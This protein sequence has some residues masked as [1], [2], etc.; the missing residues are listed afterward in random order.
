MSVNSRTVSVVVTAYNTEDRFLR[1]CLRSILAQEPMPHEVIL[2]DDGSVVPPLWVTSEFPS[3]QLHVQANTGV[4]GARD[5]GRRM[6]TGTHVMICDGDDR[7]LPGALAAL[8]APFDSVPNLGFVAGRSIVIDEN[9]QLVPDQMIRVVPKDARYYDL[10][11]RSWICPPSSVLFRADALAE[12]GGTITTSRLE[13]WDV[14]LNVG[15]RFP[16]VAITDIVTDYRRHSTN[17]SNDLVFMMR[18]SWR[19]MAMELAKH[20]DDPRIRDCVRRAK[21]HYRLLWV[22]GAAV[23][24]L[25]RAQNRSEWRRPGELFR[26]LVLVAEELPLWMVARTGLL[27]VATTEWEPISSVP[28]TAAVVPAPRRRDHPNRMRWVARANHLVR[29]GGGRVPSAH[30]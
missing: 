16:F 6:A 22:R 20:P 21:R 25:R 26:D 27:P 7:L 23:D 12:A 3:V 14:L 11:E 9:S 13:D 29:S 1:E 28:V 18:A 30:T 19:Q 8:A 24:T 10:L 4:G 17:V 15:W 5:A 2:V